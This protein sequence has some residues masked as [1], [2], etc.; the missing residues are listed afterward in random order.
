MPASPTNRADRL[1]VDRPVILMLMAFVW[2]MFAQP[3]EPGR[4]TFSVEYFSPNFSSGH[5]YRLYHS[6]SRAFT[7]AATYR[8]QT[9]ETSSILVILPFGWT[10]LTYDEH[11]RYGGPRTRQVSSTYGIGNIQLGS[12]YRFPQSGRV[13]R[14]LVSLPTIAESKKNWVTGAWYSDPMHIERYAVD[15]AGVTGDYFYATPRLGPAEFN[16][17]GGIGA[18]VRVMGESQDPIA[19]A[20]Y[21]AGVAVHAGSV[22]LVGLVEGRKLL[23]VEVDVEAESYSFLFTEFEA[24]VTLGAVQPALILRLPLNNVFQEVTKSVVGVSVRVE[25]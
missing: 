25:M 6:L 5:Y 11:P 4:S 12:E 9:N 3:V 10:E 22:R 1:R 23:S 21:G 19:F 7:G 2:P 15:N 8:M 13:F 14:I 16:V 20:S 17:R 24:S 18:F